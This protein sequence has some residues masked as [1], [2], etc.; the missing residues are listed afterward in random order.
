[1]P[2]QRCDQ[3]VAAPAGNAVFVLLRAPSGHGCPA[4]QPKWTRWPDDR[5]EMALEGLPFVF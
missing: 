5:R 2:L 4:P 1:L 3:L